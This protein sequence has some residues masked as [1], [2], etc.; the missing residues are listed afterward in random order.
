MYLQPFSNVS[1]AERVDL[2]LSPTRKVTH[3]DAFQPGP[4]CQAVTK[5]SQLA[6]IHCCCEM[7]EHGN[8]FYFFMQV[9]AYL[10]GNMAVPET[11][12]WV[13]AVEIVALDTLFVTCTSV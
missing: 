11:S 12:I 7:S 9:S 13:G 1:P 2:K 3:N 10:K 5:K 8:T 6:E 4:P